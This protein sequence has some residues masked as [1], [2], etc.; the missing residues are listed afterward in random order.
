MHSFS[1]PQDQHSTMVVY[2]IPVAPGGVAEIFDQLESNKNALK[3][4]HFS[5]SQTTLDEVRKKETGHK[6]GEKQH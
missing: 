5:V 4:K 1:I 2:H 3:I 6:Q